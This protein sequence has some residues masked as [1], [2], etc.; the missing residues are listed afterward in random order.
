[1]KILKQ[2]LPTIEFHNSALFYSRHFAFFVAK[3]TSG[4][5]A[6][7]ACATSKSITFWAEFLSMTTFTVHQTLVLCYRGAVQSFVAQPLDI[8]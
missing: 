2:Q 6:E 3:L 1:M 5:H 7:C 8:R 4:L